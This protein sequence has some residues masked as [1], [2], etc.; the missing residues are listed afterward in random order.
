MARD[1]DDDEGNVFLGLGFLFAPLI[2]A[3]VSWGVFPWEISSMQFPIRYCSDN[4]AMVY[5]NNML[6]CRNATSSSYNQT[7][8]IGISPEYASIFST[9]TGYDAPAWQDASQSVR[10]SDFTKEN[11]CNR[12]SLIYQQYALPNGICSEGG[13]LLVGGSYISTAN[14][15]IATMVMFP[16]CLFSSA[17]LAWL[18]NTQN[19]TSPLCFSCVLWVAVL[20]TAAFTMYSWNTFAVPM[21]YV[22]WKST[23]VAPIWNVTFVDPR[24]SVIYTIQ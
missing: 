21:N 7:Y 2:L 8:R 10:W 12:A 3:G 9:K 19:W 6:Y 11:M 15:A 24:Y 20:I 18:S 5:E 22:S 1:S 23:N 17:A 4:S 13:E 14:A 16:T